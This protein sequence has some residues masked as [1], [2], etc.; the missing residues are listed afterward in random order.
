MIRF[1]S[2]DTDWEG[3]NGSEWVSLGG[4]TDEDYGLI[5]TSVTSTVDYGD[6]S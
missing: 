1:N 5:T 2:T 6:L 3:Y 4:G